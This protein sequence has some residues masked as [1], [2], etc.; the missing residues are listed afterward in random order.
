MNYNNCRANRQTGYNLVAD[1]FFLFDN[2]L[3]IGIHVFLSLNNTKFYFTY[4]IISQNISNR[5]K[6]LQNVMVLTVNCKKLFT[7][8]RNCVRI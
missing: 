1:A 8:R 3:A 4:G 2:I 7:Y 5:K 6:L